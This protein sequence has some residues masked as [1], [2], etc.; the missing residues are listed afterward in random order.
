MHASSDLD[1]NQVAHPKQM[2]GDEGDLTSRGKW[3]AQGP[4]AAY[5][6]RGALE[7]VHTIIFR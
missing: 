7:I 3:P 2:V 6:R 5:G 4:S 1:R